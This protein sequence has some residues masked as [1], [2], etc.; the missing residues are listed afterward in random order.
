MRAS[1]LL[2]ILITLQARGRVTA[3][4]LAEDSEVSVRTIYR[5]I[6]AL[7]AAGVPVY[8]DRGS[9]GGYRLLDGYRT[10]LNGLS[11]REVEALFLSGLPGAAAALGL[12]AAMAAAQLKVAAALPPELQ[13][14]AERMRTRFH[15]DAPAWF[16]APEA[17]EHLQSLSAA[18]WEER[19]VEIRYRSWKAEKERRVGPLGLVLKSGAWYLAGAVGGDVRTYRVARIRELRILNACF[20]RP[21]DFDLAGYWRDSTR[22]LEAELHPGR[23]VVRLTPMGLK[24]LEP[25][26]SP[27]ARSGMEVGEPDVRGDCI[28]VLP[29]GSMREACSELLRFGI[30]AEVLGPPELRA[31][32]GEIIQQLAT[33]YPADVGPASPA[34]KRVPQRQS[35]SRC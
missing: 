4:A 21:A 3:Q 11:A 34:D 7:S 22:R 12:D 31:R 20:E 24:M 29:V 30:E 5:D 32:V 1:R 18:V 6:D 27:F 10:R 9:A 8:A 25:L 19:L 2:S 16:H 26:T 33:I 35:G 13:S 14:A 17:P 23:A 15:L 28:V